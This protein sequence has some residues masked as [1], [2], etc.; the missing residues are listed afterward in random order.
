MFLVFSV[1]CL[2]KLT[3]SHFHSSFLSCT[4]QFRHAFI[5]DFQLFSYV[6]QISLAPQFCL[7]EH[8]KSRK[9]Q[10]QILC[11]FYMDVRFWLDNFFSCA[12]FLTSR[13]QYFGQ[14]VLVFLTFFRKHLFIS[15]LTSHSRLV[16]DVY[17][18]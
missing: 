16:V 13:Y 15:T 12:I 4:F 7:S 8:W 11:P 14:L 18:A 5:R 9:K 17:L 1:H 2:A 3:S 6:F 10:I